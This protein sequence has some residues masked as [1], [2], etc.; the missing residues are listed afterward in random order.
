MIF[1][2]PVRMLLLISI[3]HS[4]WYIF[5]PFFNIESW[6][7]SH[8]SRLSSLRLHVANAVPFLQEFFFFLNYFLFFN[9]C[10]SLFCS[11]P[12]S[13]LYISFP[14]WTDGSFHSAFQP[15]YALPALVF[16][17]GTSLTFA[18][19]CSGPREAISQHC[20]FFHTS[21][22]AVSHPRPPPFQSK[23]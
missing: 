1:Q 23:G 3:Q 12:F 18:M 22:S 5:L 13:P 19:P 15:Y 21:P 11:L 6:T 4:C 2:W 9:M 7:G 8:T 17:W 10:Y 16:G 20:W 14:H